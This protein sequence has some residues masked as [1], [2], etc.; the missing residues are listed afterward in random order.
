[1]PASL[2]DSVVVVTGASSGI[3]RATTL[4][5]AR[6]GAA[7][8]VAARR[9]EPLDSLV[10]ECRALGASALAV[11]TDV[12]DE[13]AVREL[14]RRPLETF[15]RLDVWVNN[16]AVGALGDFEAIPPDV[17]RRIVDVDFFGYVHGAR[18]ALAHFR[19]QG[20]GV[21]VNVAS[22]L[23]KMAMPYYTAYVAAKFAVVGFSETLR[24]ELLGTGINVVTIMPAAI[25][26]PFF[27]HSAN[28]TGRAL[29]PPRPVYD[30][31]SV[32][33]A[34]VDAARRPRRERFVGGAARA[35]HALHLLAPA[36]YERVARIMTD[37]DHFQ[38]APALPTP[39]AALTPMPE[40]T[41]VRGGWRTA[42]ATRRR[43]RA[44]VGVALVV[45]A[46]LA[47]RAARRA[48]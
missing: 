21:V 39:G 8:V 46:L 48:A 32:A 5:F 45:P 7:V 22:M 27:E 41:E 35:M 19:A 15:G 36:L 33:A 2:S 13:R 1:M 10:E 3:G 26:T 14:A 23:G 6:E 37:H 11:P 20:E 28:Y 29:K 31:E 4:A 9:T 18:A 12:T 40:G 25:D 42:P 43:R 47:W 30:P 44:A 38:D 16:A 17:F 34:I 24:Q